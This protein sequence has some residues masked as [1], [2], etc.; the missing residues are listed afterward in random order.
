M[1][2]IELV[3]ILTLILYL[4]AIVV[5]PISF[6]L[7]AKILGS[8]NPNSIKN[9]TFECGQIASGEPHARLGVQYVPYVVVYATIG[10]LAVLL[11]LSAPSL[12]SGSVSRS[13]LAVSLIA[14]VM[15]LLSV[16]ISFE[17]KGG[18]VWRI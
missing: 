9:S 1:F 16:A 11:L 14:M 15:G 7:L 2:P 3:D 6:V 17:R 12:L 4:I 10:V 18:R 5:L 13:I 8:S